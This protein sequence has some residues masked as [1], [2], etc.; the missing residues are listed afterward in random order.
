[1][2][3]AIDS[4]LVG[5][6]PT[7]AL[8]LKLY[9]LS[10]EPDQELV[11][12]SQRLGVIGPEE[13]RVSEAGAV[14]RSAGLWAHEEI[15]QNARD[16][17]IVLLGAVEPFDAAVLES[18]PN[19]KAVVRRGVGVDNVD[20]G[21]ATRLGVVIANVPDASVEEVSDH[22]LGLL[23]SIE[24]AI[25]WLDQAVRDGLW[26]KDPSHIQAVRARSRRLSDLTVGVVGLGRIGLAFA[27][28][29]RHIY[30]AMLGSD[31]FVTETTAT[32]LGIRL[33]PVDQLLAQADHVTLHAPL[34]PG[35]Q[36]LINSRSLLSMRPGAV[37]V[38]T[39]RGGL[40]DADA[41][42][43]AVRDGRLAG[44]GLD[45]TDPEPLPAKHALLQSERILL[46]AH[47]ASTSL[48]TAMELA[49]RSVDAVIALLDQRSPD[50]IVNPEVID[51]PQLRLT[52]LRAAR[53]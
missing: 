26:A 48:T 34:L 44:A 7:R 33:V 29:A 50:A 21:A 20:V 27:R 6:A 5:R 23:L 28:K 52:E 40:V 10:M 41:V 13:M 36:H 42:M 43:D 12:I 49:R 17:S 38:N 25:P 37:L 19:L 9:T 30:G 1:M 32:D 53:R 18:L 47:S 31:P 16:A 3:W 39:A 24:R 46:T 45:V 14:I 51:T 22:A 8:E 35:T 2:G 4:S 15:R 11:V